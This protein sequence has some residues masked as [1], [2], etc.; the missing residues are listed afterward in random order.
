M[1]GVSL[2]SVVVLALGA[3]ALD[4]LA[5]AQSCPPGYYYASDGNCYPGPPPAYSPPVYDYTP[6]VYQPPPVY[7]GFALG[8]GLGALVGILGRDHR[9]DDRRGDQDNRGRA[10]DRRGR[11]SGDRGER[12]HH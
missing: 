7:D 5:W 12:D 3:G 11:P 10:P 2:L 8:I 6:P 4:G 1:R 9:G